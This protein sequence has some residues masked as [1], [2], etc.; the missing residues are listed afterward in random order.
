MSLASRFM[1]QKK[2]RAQSVVWLTPP[3][4]LE[5]LGEFDLDPCAA[6]GQPWRTARKMLTRLED[7]LS[8]R[9]VGRCFVNPPYGLSSVKFISKLAAHGDGVLLVTLRGDTHYFHDHVWG[10]AHSMLVIRRRVRF[11]KIDG[12]CPGGDT[13]GCTAL[14][15][16]GEKN[17]DCLMKMRDIG[18][19]TTLDRR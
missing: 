15:A 9:W 8:A 13:G 18:Y 5:R 4:L 7:G 10:V 17:A 1:M 11:F 2:E 12:T 3:W 14:F 6:V 19:Y 16:Y